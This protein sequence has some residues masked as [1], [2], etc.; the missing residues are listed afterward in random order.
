M[1]ESGNKARY[2]EKLDHLLS[3]LLR[4]RASMEPLLNLD[5]SYETA[6]CSF[7]YSEATPVESLELSSLICESFGSLLVFP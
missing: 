4:H 1:R 7:L 2:S 5:A 6:L 3:L